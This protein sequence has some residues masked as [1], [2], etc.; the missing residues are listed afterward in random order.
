VRARLRMEAI[1]GSEHKAGWRSGVPLRG[2]ALRDATTI[3]IC[4]RAARAQAGSFLTIA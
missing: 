4:L 3:T 2:S 1:L